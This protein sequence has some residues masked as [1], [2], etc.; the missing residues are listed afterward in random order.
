VLIKSPL[1]SDA[2]IA[3]GFFGRKGGVSTGI[4]SSLN[5]GYG[6]SCDPKENITE[7]RKIVADCLEA[8]PARLVGVYQFHSADIVTYSAA[9]QQD[10]SPKADAIV[11][12]TPN[13]A[14]SVLTAD[15]APVLF[16]D[17]KARVVA[18]AH[19]GWQGAFKG[20]VENTIDAMLKL[21]A[22]RRDI[23]ATVG[24]TISA[25]SY[26]V[27]EEFYARFIRQASENE[28]FF[29]RDSA[30]KFNL[31]EYVCSRLHDAGISMV[32][33][34]ATCTYANVDE[35]F[36]YRR[37][38]HAREPDYGRQISAIMLRS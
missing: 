4:Y 36:S 20:I 31:P 38:I 26:E 13:V 7:N 1:I 9:W 8:M 33:H 10:S 37:S 3:H 32:H 18:V 15:C 34:M 35:Y 6:A 12:N 21:G 2:G 29:T 19:A 25:H 14:I 24:P 22:D 27:G 5:C 11:C 28:R 30:L 16:A 17:P 23:S